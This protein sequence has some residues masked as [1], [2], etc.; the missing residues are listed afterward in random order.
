M[1]EYEKTP[2]GVLSPDKVL[3]LNDSI[4]A[5]LSKYDI[6]HPKPSISRNT[7]RKMLTRDLYLYLSK[8][9]EVK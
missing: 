4:E 1:S 6:R 5:V 2:E 9:I 3:Y 8:R 7:A